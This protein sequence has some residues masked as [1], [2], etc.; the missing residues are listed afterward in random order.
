[1]AE[2]EDILHHV[3]E[4]AQHEIIVLSAMKLSRDSWLK[5]V[6]DLDYVGD[7][8]QKASSRLGI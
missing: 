4:F 5:N 7:L 6:I 2:D 1:V 3:D 8:A